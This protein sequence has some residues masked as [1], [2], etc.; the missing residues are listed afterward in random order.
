MTLTRV[1]F[2][3]W[4]A[5]STWLLHAHEHKEDKHTGIS[6]EKIR[7]CCTRLIARLFIYR[8]LR[9]V[10]YYQR[11]YLV[12]YLEWYQSYLVFVMY[13][14]RTRYIFL[15]CSLNSPCNTWYVGY[16]LFIQCDVI[17]LAGS[18]SVTWYLVC[19]TYRMVHILL[20]STRG[21]YTD[22]YHQQMTRVLATV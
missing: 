9:Q 16:M 12:L 5:T 20:L 3:F 13:Q 21:M 18:K 7:N 19:S 6:K 17:R 11:R 4:I 1:T 10:R 8:Y 14:V 22:V 15:W 2:R